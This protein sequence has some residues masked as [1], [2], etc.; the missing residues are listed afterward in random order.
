MNSIST[1]SQ[2]GG[3]PLP[4]LDPTNRSKDLRI[5][6]R[7][8]LLRIDML[9]I[10]PIYHPPT[11]PVCITWK[12][13]IAII[14]SILIPSALTFAR[15]AGHLTIVRVE[16]R[17]TLTLVGVPVVVVVFFPA[18]F[19]RSTITFT[20]PALRD[21]R[22]TRGLSHTFGR[23]LLFDS[24]LWRLRRNYFETEACEDCPV[25][26]D[27]CGAGGTIN[28]IKIRYGI[29]IRWGERYRCFSNSIN[30]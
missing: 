30:S 6:P 12:H 22:D 18:L 27:V 15:P 4:H 24:L 19:L 8:P 5:R 28:I 20:V 21:T 23:A 17:I 14:T 9:N 29:I 3:P 1:A 10:P 25:S 11:Q 26:G 2:S 7:I 13:N 16:I